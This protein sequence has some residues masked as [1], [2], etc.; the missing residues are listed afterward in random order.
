MK[1]LFASEKLM[2]CVINKE[3]NK[4][5]L[6]DTPHYDL[7]DDMA[8]ICRCVV[9]ED[10]EGLS[11]AIIKNG[12]L[13]ELELKKEELFKIAAGNT[14]KLM[15][16]AISSMPGMLVATNENAFYGAN[17]ILNTEKLKEIAEMLEEDFYILPTSIHECIIVPTSNHELEALKNTLLEGN[18]LCV[19]PEEFLS[20]TVYMYD[21]VIGAVVKAGA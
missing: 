11:S 17:A 4:N 5:L 2:L 13:E 14:F 6:E 1:E 21:N 20:N 8:V 10:E 12:L 3:R 16:I 18:R 7:F 15:P 19:S 9:S